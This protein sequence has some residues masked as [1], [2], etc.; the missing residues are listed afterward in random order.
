MHHISHHHPSFGQDETTVSLVITGN[1]WNFRDDLE[2]NGIQGARAS[3]EG[4]AYYRYL[5]NVDVSDAV[6][7][8]QIVSPCGI[9]KQAL[10]VVVDPKPHLDTP[11]AAF[12][13][14]LHKLA[15]LHFFWQMYARA[16]DSR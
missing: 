6:G 9:F 2:R 5:K 7:K 11:C 8:Q 10:R 15:C 4:G 12:F 13:D 14:E 3:D 1:T 16:L